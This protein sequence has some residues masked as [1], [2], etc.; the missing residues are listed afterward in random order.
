MSKKEK[1]IEYYSNGIIKETI[2]N[3]IIGLN[4]HIDTIK[5]HKM[6]IVDDQINIKNPILLKTKI[7]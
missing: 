3:I 4:Q 5:F 2:N 7:N 6:K 1:Y